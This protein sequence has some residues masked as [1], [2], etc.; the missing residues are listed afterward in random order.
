HVDAVRPDRPDAPADL[1]VAAPAAFDEEAVTTG[2]RAFERDDEDELPSA[3]LCPLEHAARE[4]AVI[5]RAPLDEAL[6]IDAREKPRTGA[7]RERGEGVVAIARGRRGSF[8]RPCVDRG[9]IQT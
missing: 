4:A 8:L 2:E 1:A 7:A 5:A 6:V 3:L 9:A